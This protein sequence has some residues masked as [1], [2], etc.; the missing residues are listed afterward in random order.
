M[1]FLLRRLFQLREHICLV[2]HHSQNHLTY[3]YILRH[4]VRKYSLIRRPLWY[5]D[6][7]FKHTQ[8][9]LSSV[10]PRFTL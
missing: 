1:L 6:S 9:F 4:L 2:S 8:I 5:E 7:V 3:I 10:R